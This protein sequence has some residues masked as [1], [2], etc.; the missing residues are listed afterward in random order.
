MIARPPNPLYATTELLCIQ[1][2]PKLLAVGTIIKHRTYKLRN[3]WFSGCREDKQ[4]DRHQW[5]NII[6]IG[7]RERISPKIRSKQMIWPNCREKGAWF[8][9]L[10]LTQNDTYSMDW[11]YDTD[12]TQNICQPPSWTSIKIFLSCT[13]YE[14][15]AILRGY[16]RE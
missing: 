10:P 6:K 5:K 7:L 9:F 14:I 11:L 15:R 8:I 1:C 16:E 2:A 3:K 13:P 12:R 4:T